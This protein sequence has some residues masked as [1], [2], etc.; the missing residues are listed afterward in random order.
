ME[1]GLDLVED[2]IAGKDDALFLDDDGGLV[3]G[4]AGHVNHAESVVAHPQDHTVLEGD[5]GNVRL[6]A[7]HQ[8]PLFRAEVGHPFDVF[9]QVGFQNAGADTFMGDYRR[10]EEGIAR[11]VVAVGFGIDDVA[12]LPVLCDFRL[13]FQCVSGLVRTVDHHDTVGGGDEAVV[14]APNLGFHINIAG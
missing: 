11:P 9:I 5:D 1:P 10:V 2:I 13:Q 4:M 6:I 12:Q 8:R 7:H 3:E 14:A